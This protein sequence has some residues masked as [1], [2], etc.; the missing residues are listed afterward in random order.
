MK[1]SDLTEIFS[2]KFIPCSVC[3]GIL[4]V[5]FVGVAEPELSS[6]YH[7]SF[8]VCLLCFFLQPV[9]AFIKLCN[10]V[11]CYFN[12]SFESLSG[13]CDLYY[14]LQEYEAVIREHSREDE[15]GVNSNSPDWYQ[16]TRLAP[17]LTTGLFCYIGNKVIY[18]SFWR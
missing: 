16:V 9:S 17:L 7:A 3:L 18:V 2:C 5:C 12:F 8:C 14:L 10:K 13:G 6:P 4:C 11:S 1:I 15:E